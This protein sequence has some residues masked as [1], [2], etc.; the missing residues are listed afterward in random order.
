MDLYRRQLLQLLGVSGIPNVDAGEVD[1]SQSTDSTFESRASGEI[2]NWM[3]HTFSAELDPN[4]IVGDPVPIIGEPDPFGHQSLQRLQFLGS[5]FEEAGNPSVSARRSIYGEPSG[6]W[7]YTFAVSGSAISH[8]EAEPSDIFARLNQIDFEDGTIDLNL[9]GRRL[10]RGATIGSRVSVEV[11]EDTSLDSVAI[12]P[13]HGADTF[14]VVTAPQP[15]G[16][17]DLNERLDAEYP[18][19]LNRC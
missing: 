2:S 10:A 16:A 19:V 15:G 7:K 18:A 11:T 8:V 1:I 13:R 5:T 4:P 14:K 3:T 9:G 12:A 6:C 17:D